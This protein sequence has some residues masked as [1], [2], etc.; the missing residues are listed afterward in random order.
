MTLDL[1]QH[2]PL[3]REL[4][5]IDKRIHQA[6]L[7]LDEIPKL[8]ET[9]GADYLTLARQIEERESKL[10]GMTAERQSLEQSLKEDQ[11]ILEKREGRLYA[12]KTQKEYQA[13][14]KEISEMKKGNKTREE[15]ILALLEEGEK[16]SAEI[17]QLKSESADKEGD[18]R[19]VEGELKTKEGELQKELEAAKARRPS[20][21]Q[22]LPKLILRK[23]DLVR[24]RYEDPLAP[25]IS[26]ICQGCSM[27]IPPQFFNE[28]LKHNDLRSCPNC[29]RLIF[30]Q[31]EEKKEENKVLDSSGVGN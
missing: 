15:R 13:T 18:F 5:E 31:R 8:L 12:I 7:E 28:M 6:E 11:A 25:V 16:I 21:F 14:L 4:Q 2:L 20:L 10:K 23:Y 19:K 3:L 26:G 24:Q 17:T 27:N 1:K 30:V 9:S 29:H 22:D